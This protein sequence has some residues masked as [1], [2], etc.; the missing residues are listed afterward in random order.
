MKFF[1]K[2]KKPRTCLDIWVPQ[3][4]KISVNGEPF[5]LRLLS[6]EDFINIFLTFF[7]E[8]LSSLKDLGI[9][10]IINGNKISLG[11]VHEI[12]RSASDTLEEI[13]KV[14]I[15]D[16]VEWEKVRPADQMKLFD[17]IW[18]YNDIPRMFECF[19]VNKARIQNLMI[20]IGTQIQKNNTAGQS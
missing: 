16:F 2:L 6:R 15:P 19:F 12:L 17:Q 18:E 5:V 3:E 20:K 7:Q 10:E 13:L 9:R 11:A 1:D 4:K 8:Y 14:S